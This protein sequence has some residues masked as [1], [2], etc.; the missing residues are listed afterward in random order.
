MRKYIRDQVIELLPTVLEGIAYAKNAQSQQAKA[1]LSD[2][3]AAVVSISEGLEAGL[4]E[5]RFHFYSNL[6]NKI[7]DILEEINENIQTSNSVEELT[8]KAEELFG[9]LE[10]HLL[11]ESEVKIEVVF[12]PYKA[13]MWDCFESIWQAAKNDERCEVTVVPIPYY[14][15]NPDLSL[16]EYHYEKNDYPQ[17]VPIVDYQEYDV[18]AR[19]PDVIYIHNPYDQYNR[20]TTV[21]PHFYSYNLKQFTDM[22]IYVPYFISGAYVN[23]DAF[24]DKHLTSCV[25]SVDKIIVQSET[26]KKLYIESGVEEQKLLALGSPKIDAIV[27]LELDSTSI[28]EEWSR[29]LENKKAIILNSSIGP[30]LNDPNY[31][32]KLKMRISEILAFE[33]LALIWRPHPLLATTITSMRP[34]WQ[35]EYKEILQ[36]VENSS[37]GILD[38]SSS[39]IPATVVSAGMISD[40]SSWARQYIATGKPVLLLNGKSEMKKDRTCVFDHFSCY[41]IYDGF[42]I[43]EFCQMIL[44]GTDVK[45]EARMRDLVNS[46]INIDG[47]CGQ[48]IHNS[49]VS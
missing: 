42:S 49:I 32:T 24:A 12:M 18:S 4:S 29:K 16:G 38:L 47:T 8:S 48:K 41:F 13:S 27:N 15:R 25:K 5:I 22:L 26:H 3:Y 7:L 44:N 17:Y 11:D 9:L 45:K 10:K 46:G 30:L 37:N 28:P 21:H 39:T 20:V 40:L 2:C 23:T 1:V 35:D 14:D 19:R 6:L 31:L 36:L 33:G 43:E 34:T